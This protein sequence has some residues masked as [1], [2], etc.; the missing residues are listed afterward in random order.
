MVALCFVL[1]ARSE[2]IFFPGLSLTSA[3]A[4]ARHAAVPSA[5]QTPA[6]QR[7]MP[8][9]GCVWLSCCGDVTVI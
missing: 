7:A 1:D 9:S 2:A 5:E 6:L 3:A 8:R 4:G